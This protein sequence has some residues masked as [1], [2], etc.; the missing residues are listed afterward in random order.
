M[1]RKPSRHRHY[2]SECF[3]AG[4]NEEE[5]VTNSPLRGVRLKKIR[6]ENGARGV[7]GEEPDPR[8]AWGCRNWESPGQGQIPDNDP[9]MFET[10]WVKFFTHPLFFRRQA[11]LTLH[12][13]NPPGKIPLPPR[14]GAHSQQLQGQASQAQQLCQLCLWA[15]TCHQSHAQEHGT[16]PG[17]AGIRIRER[18]KQGRNCSSFSR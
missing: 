1:W 6:T 5:A 15:S 18:E 4:S 14:L 16:C 3:R 9:E 7:G 2:P 13:C 17:V 10:K 12:P 11:L 8:P